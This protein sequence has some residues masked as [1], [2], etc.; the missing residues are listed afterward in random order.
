[1]PAEPLR[2]LL[3]LLDPSRL[4]AWKL[5]APKTASEPTHPASRHHLL[6]DVTS[7][8]CQ[9]LCVHPVSL[10]ND[11]LETPCL[12]LY[13]YHKHAFRS[14]NMYLLLLKIINSSE[15]FITT[16]Q[17]FQVSLAAPSLLR[18]AHCKMRSLLS[19]QSLQLLKK[20]GNLL[21]EGVFSWL[22]WFSNP[23]LFFENQ[24]L[25][26]LQLCF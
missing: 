25:K 22:G 10:S 24:S 11:K 23:R 16:A 12:G 20:W 7:H 2:L 18:F 6:L 26:M 8:T 5:C 9:A 3:P 14:I 19:V 21:H 1:M 15:G 4:T 17:M 13:L